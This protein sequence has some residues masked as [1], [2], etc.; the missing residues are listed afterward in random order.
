MNILC[1]VTAVIARPLA[2]GKASCRSALE[3]GLCDADGKRGNGVEFVKKYRK[4]YGKQFLTAVI[5]V[6]L[7]AV[8]DLLQPT[9]M[10][11]IIDVGVAGR[12]LQYILH[13]G[14]I[15]LSVTAVGAIAAAARNI[16]SSRV[17]QRL[18][19]ELRMDLYEKIHSLS[20]AGINRLDRASLLTRITNDV[21]QVQALVNGLMR[22]FLKAPLLCIGG[23]IMAV[24]L[25]AHLAVVLATVVPVV[26]LLIV[27]NM[28]IGFPLFVKVQAA[29]DRVNGVLREYLAGVRVIKAFNRFDYEVDKFAGAN[30]NL[31]TRSVMVMRV[32]ALFGPGVTLTLNIGI[33]LVL[34]LGGLGVS[35]GY[36]QVG[37]IVAFINYMT[38]ILFSLMIIFM[39]FN[40]LV[41]AEASARRIEEVFLQPTG[42][43]WDAAVSPVATTQ[44]AGGTVEFENVYFSYDES[45]GEPVLKNISLTCKPGQ[46]IG[47]IGTTGAGKS[48]LVN[49]IPRL[50][51]STS[52]IVRVNGDNVRCINPKKLRETIAV[53]PQNTV[54]FTGTIMDNIKWGRADAGMDEVEMA[55]TMAQAYEFI[56]SLPEGYQTKLG[57]GG[58]NLSGGQK[59][60]VSIARALVRNPEIL[61]LDDC[62]SAVDVETEAGIKAAIRKYAGQVTC[63]IIGQRIT[64]VIDA[65]QILVMDGGH[66]VGTGRHDE[67]IKTCRIYQETFQSQMGRGMSRHASTK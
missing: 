47:I 1:H 58:V 38:Q 66:I 39:V 44:A 60:R 45:S 55:A 31:Q 63:F 7:E 36:M 54:L 64:S 65:D 53:V 33:V 49:L 10:S 8:C 22:I 56:R 9:I 59:Q 34:W 16:I 67:L 28:K 13:M 43:Q 42:M 37:H 30:K 2:P 61:I 21:T 11:H 3:P 18:G 40:M 15:M 48:T 19:A 32:M 5:F 14:G 24:S 41:R 23:I 51:D 50:Y 57:Q 29:I 12:N 26:G 17:S 4:R 27:V 62:T 35:G 46:V 6:T 52:G 20:L 25:N